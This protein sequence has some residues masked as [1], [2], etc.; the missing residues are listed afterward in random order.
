MEM[1]MAMVRINWF[2]FGPYKL[3]MNELFSINVDWDGDLEHN[4]VVV[5]VFLSCNPSVGIVIICYRG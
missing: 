2:F 3:V 5:H 1:A 4:V